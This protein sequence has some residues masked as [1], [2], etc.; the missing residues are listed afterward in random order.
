VATV[1]G[2][3]YD[4]DRDA[5]AQRYAIVVEAASEVHSLV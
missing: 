1:I 3:G 2:G 4:D 5:L